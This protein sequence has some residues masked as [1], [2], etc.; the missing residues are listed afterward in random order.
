MKPTFQEERICLYQADALPVLAS[1]ESGSVDALIADPPYSSG[2]FTRSDRSADPE[3]KYIQTGTLKAWTSFAGDNRDAR[4][5]SWWCYLW[6]S[7]A[8]RV[9]RE[10]GYALM[11]TDW[12]QLP[13]AS[14]TI[15][16]LPPPV[17][18]HRLGHQGS[19]QGR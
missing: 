3:S 8:F 4:S 19:E 11:F 10:S 2:G 14:D 7:E 6:L 17:R 13:M 5:W 12:R 16:L 15:Q 18:V 1:L 9:V